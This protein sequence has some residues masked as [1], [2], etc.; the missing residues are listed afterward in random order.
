MHHFE[1]HIFEKFVYIQA[2]LPHLIPPVM[3]AHEAFGFA[4]HRSDQPLGNWEGRGQCLLLR[5]HAGAVHGHK[6][7]WSRPF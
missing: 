4:R 7:K 2:E 5:G 6:E 1:D 3:D